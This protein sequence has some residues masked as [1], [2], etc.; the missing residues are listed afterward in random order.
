MSEQLLKQILEE[1]SEIKSEVTER[2]TSIESKQL[3]SYGQTGRRTVNSKRK[4]E[5]CWRKSWI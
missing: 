4:G 1:I 3:I 5:D 2:L